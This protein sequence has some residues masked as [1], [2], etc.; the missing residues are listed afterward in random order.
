MYTIFFFKFQR[1]ISRHSE[2]VCVCVLRVYVMYVYI[3][4][5]IYLVRRRE[6]AGLCVCV[7]LVVGSLSRFFYPSWPRAPAAFLPSSS[8]E[9]CRR[10]ALIAAQEQYTTCVSRCESGR[11]LRLCRRPRVDPSVSEREKAYQ[12]SSISSSSSSSTGSGACSR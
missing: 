7:C 5:I 2:C 10:L 8:P 4:I 3:I 12:G 6:T 1:K 9:G 11:E